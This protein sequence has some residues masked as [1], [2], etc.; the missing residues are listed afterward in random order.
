[1]TQVSLIG[2][3]SVPRS[4]SVHGR[5]ALPVSEDYGYA[6]AVLPF[7]TIVDPEIP[8]MGNTPA[9]WVTL[10][11]SYSVARS[12]L[13]MLQFA[14][15][16]AT[17]VRSSEGDQVKLYGFA[18]FSLTV[19]PYATMSLINLIA[20]LICPRYPSLYMVRNS[21]MDE[22]EERFGKTF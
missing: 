19:T 18:S 11:C 21:V 9:S 13:A 8:V 12:L 4:M 10:S 5:I 17:L 22:A 2:S 15:A 14:F 1:M 6:L 16:I 3:S 20:T 7:D